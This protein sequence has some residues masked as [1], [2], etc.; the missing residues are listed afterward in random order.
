LIS[1]L[2]FCEELGSEKKRRVGIIRVKSGVA[3]IEE[4]EE[5]EENKKEISRYK[6][7]SSAVWA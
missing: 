2:T 7:T 4:G 5:E 6:A 1:F 3:K